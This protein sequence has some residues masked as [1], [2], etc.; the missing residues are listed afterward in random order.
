[1]IMKK[2]LP[3]NLRTAMKWYD[4]VIYDPK[5]DRL[6]ASYGFSL[7]RAVNS[8]SWEI[9]AAMLLKLRKAGHSGEDLPG[10][11]IKSARGDAPDG[12]TR[13]N[14][15]YYPLSGLQKLKN[16]RSLQHMYIVYSDAYA[17][18]DVW[19]LPGQDLVPVFKVWKTA[20][21]EYLRLG[22]PNRRDVKKALPY[23][24]VKA[25]GQQV[26]QIRKGTLTFCDEML[27]GKGGV[28]HNDNG[29]LCGFHGKN[30]TP[31]W[32]CLCG[33][34]AAARYRGVICPKCNVEVTKSKARNKVQSR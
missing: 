31:S 34:Y 32:A 13:F 18:V 12:S 9:F 1:M 5:R 4:D 22:R 19:V 3:E 28:Y 8:T 33:K 24:Y 6:S 26:M 11:E 27:G 10:W 7:S 20:I 14:Y 30:W 29:I 21:S 2:T 16:E 23:G 25:H 15:E 17:S